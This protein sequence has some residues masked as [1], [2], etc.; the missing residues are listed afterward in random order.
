MLPDA[1]G[2]TSLKRTLSG[3]SDEY[4]QRIR[5]EVLATTAGDFASFGEVLDSVARSGRVVVL[6]SEDAIKETNA[7]MGEEWLQLIPVL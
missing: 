3:V 1:K 5:N 2:F 4:R 6:G 7:K